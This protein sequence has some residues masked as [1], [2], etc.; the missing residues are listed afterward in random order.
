MCIRN[1]GK[2]LKPYVQR[3]AEKKE[4]L[5]QQIQKEPSGGW[6]IDED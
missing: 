5:N 6:I 4:I 2:G 1:F 3:G